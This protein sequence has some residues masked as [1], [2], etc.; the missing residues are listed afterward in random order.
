M[1]NA[2]MELVEFEGNMNNLAIANIIV[3]KRCRDMKEDGIYGK[4][5]SAL[6]DT[7]A[8]SLFT[9]SKGFLK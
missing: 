9:S 3:Y 8:F 6:F 4:A 5:V 7:I 1:A 2:G